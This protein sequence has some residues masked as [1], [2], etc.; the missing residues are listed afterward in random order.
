LVIVSVP[1]PVTGEPETV[2]SEGT[3]RLTLVTVPLF[4][5]VGV[6]AKPLQASTWPLAGAVDETP[7]PWRAATR[8]VPLVPPRSPASCNAPCAELVAAGNWAALAV[9]LRLLKAG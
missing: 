2:S 1:E 5:I 3:D 7:F 8:G 6:Q 9:P 4:G